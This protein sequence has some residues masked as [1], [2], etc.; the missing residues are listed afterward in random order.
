MVLRKC[1]DSMVNVYTCKELQMVK[2]QA[3]TAVFSLTANKPKI[4][5]IPSRG[6]RMIVAFRMALCN[7]IVNHILTTTCTVFYEHMLCSHQYTS[8][9][10]CFCV[11]LTCR[12]YTCT[13]ISH[14]STCVYTL[15]KLLHGKFFITFSWLFSFFL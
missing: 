14:V 4:Q 13:Y 10:T 1:V 15:N 11:H 8:K 12:V 6:S 2:S 5:V 9:C 7:I 3:K